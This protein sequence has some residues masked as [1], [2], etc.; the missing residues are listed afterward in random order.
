MKDYT[1]EDVRHAYLIFLGREPENEK[2]VDDHCRS[3]KS[4]SELLYAFWSSD[5]FK[6]KRLSEIKASQKSIRTNS[7]SLHETA[8]GKYFLPT[9]AHQDGIANTIIKGGIFDTPIYEIAKQYIKHG[10]T[11]LDVGSNFGQM[12]VLFS[13]LVGDQGVVHAFEADDFVFH[14]LEK[15]IF[16]N[17]CFNIKAHFGAVHNVSGATLCFPVQ[18]FERFGTYGSYGIDYKNTTQG[19]RQVKTMAID[20]FEFE[21]PISFMKVDVQGGDLFVLR[22]AVKTIEKYRMPIIF[23]YEYLFEDELSLN[24]QEYVDFVQ[25]INYRF[26]KVILGQNYLIV[27][28]PR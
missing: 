9:D 16:I 22:G 24:F 1:R 19:G 13:K 21:L 11:V 23:E 20:D 2:A 14:I 15:N 3:H 5:E 18:D 12:A 26:E 28:N 17:N 4:L 27:P 25:S 6:T 8:T 10:T 7:L